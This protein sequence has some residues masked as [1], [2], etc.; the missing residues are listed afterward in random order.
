[1]YGILFSMN[2]KYF[3]QAINWETLLLASSNNKD[4]VES[5][6]QNNQAYFATP[7]LINFSHFATLL[8]IK[9][10]ELSKIYYKVRE[11]FESL[12]DET[13]ILSENDERW[14]SRINNFP[15]CPKFIYC[16]GDIE[17]LKKK[18]IIIAGTKSPT[19]EDK[20]SVTKSVEAFVKN[21]IVI[22]TGLSLGI[23]GLASAESIKHFAPTIAVIGTSL[24][25]Y[26]PI[27]HEKL[28]SF[29][30]EQGGVV[31]TM[32]PPS[33]AP[34]NFKFNFLL[35]NRLLIALSNALLIIDERDRGASVKMAEVALM[36][37]R[38]VYFYSSL[39]KQKDLN[40][41]LIMR[42][43]VNVKVVRYPGNLVRDL[44][45]VKTSKS[46]KAKKE[47]KSKQLSLF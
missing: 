46:I 47:I 34:Q 7:M 8:S 36:N 11:S 41:P 40:W 19:P 1:M 42:D 32:T 4:L 18:I 39:L 25:E 14:P 23:E 33:S 2:D 27:N 37:S 29:I 9:T 30:A 22:A 6:W 21:E 3:N 35:R 13:I 43:R 10:Y 28:Q 17:L 12:P 20:L 15:Y 38:K 44:L 31:V 16:L 26:Y 24:N 45:G 5:I